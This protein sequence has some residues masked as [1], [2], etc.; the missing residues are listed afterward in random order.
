MLILN[1]DH[2]KNS[3]SILDALKAV[4]EAFLTQEKG[5]FIMPDR[6]HVEHQGN[7]LLVMP[8][9]GGEF[10]STKL[11]SV[12]PE[13][14]KKDIP[15]IFGAVILSDGESGKPLALLEGSTLTA[16]RTG[17]VG[18]LATA[19]TTPKNITKLGLAGAG[20]QGFHQALFAATVRN[21][22]QIMVFDPFKKEMNEFTGQLQKL[23][24]HVQISAT[25]DI[26]EC[27]RNSEVI[28]TA[29]TAETPVIPDDLKLLEGK[30][31]IGMGS[32]KPS[33]REYPDSLF[34]L[35]GETV[36]DTPYAA[37]E[38]GDLKIPLEKGLT[39]QSQII[40]LG[41]LINHEY[42]L[43]T[44]RTTF[45]KSVGMALF[46]LFAARK[47]YKNAVEKGIGIEVDF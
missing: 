7:V 9:F 34:S 11:V 29:T 36:V 13:N 37:E 6:M 8:A 45:F 28:I 19:Y 47:V 31:F 22:T 38:S 40:T 25:K 16:L 10:I 24:P 26:S 39:G 20:T 5:G 46:D 30:H 41:K 33:M 32:Y 44:G 1:A 15:S 42:S 17:A 12:F 18:G 23:L 35:I 2:I 4:E 27:I 43:D 21:I 14:T 3:L